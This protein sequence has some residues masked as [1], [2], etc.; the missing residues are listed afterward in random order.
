MIQK[1]L[2]L[3]WETFLVSLFPYS[4]PYRTKFSYY[5]SQQESKKF[6]LKKSIIQCMKT[7]IFDIDK[8][9]DCRTKS[10]YKSRYAY[11]KYKYTF[12]CLYQ[13]HVILNQSFLGRQRTK[14]EYSPPHPHPFWAISIPI[15]RWWWSFRYSHKKIITLLSRLS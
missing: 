3:K 1:L 7:S 10:P 11:N 6:H 2:R 5:T 13:W 8:D 12:F 15:L 9:G 4:H 14:F